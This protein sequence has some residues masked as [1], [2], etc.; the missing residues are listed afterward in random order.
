MT[1]NINH[2]A[3]RWWSQRVWF[4]SLLVV[5]VETTSV[6]FAFAQRPHERSVDSATAGEPIRLYLS[7]IRIDSGYRLTPYGYSGATHVGQTVDFSERRDSSRRA[8]VIGVPTRAMDTWNAVQFVSPPLA[9]PFD[10]SG[11][12]SGRLEL[13]SNKPEFGFQIALFELTPTGDYVLVSS[14]S[15]RETAIGEASHRMSLQTGVREFVDY[16]SARFASRLIQNGSKLVVLI[17]I[18]KL[19]GSQ[20]DTRGNTAAATGDADNVPLKVGWYGNSYI[21]LRV[22]HH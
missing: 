22:R 19:S 3:C 10:L 8:S 6:S 9:G 4:A 15:T 7:P 20:S 12:F 17:T 11:E 16:H 2:T 21:D 5:A 18:L 13:I 14:Y 1:N